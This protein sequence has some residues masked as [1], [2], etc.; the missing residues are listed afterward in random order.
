MTDAGGPA[1]MLSGVKRRA[2]APPSTAGGWMAARPPRGYIRRWPGQARQDLAA[3]CTC[4]STCPGTRA[5]EPRPGST[6]APRDPA[7]RDILRPKQRNLW[8]PFPPSLVAVPALLVITA[9][10]WRPPRPAA[11]GA[12]VRLLRLA[13]PAPS[14]HHRFCTLKSTGP[15]PCSRQHIAEAKS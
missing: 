15:R 5:S 7:S 9:R 14:N 8:W 1:A 6:R 10:G 13:S 12:L 4:T 3:P 2:T 11:G